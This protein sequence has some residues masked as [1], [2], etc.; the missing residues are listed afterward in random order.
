MALNYGYVKCTVVS[1]PRRKPSRHGR[2]TQ[3]HLHA[4]LK[5]PSGD[6]EASWDTAINVG[7]NDA[8]D[9]LRYKLVYDFHHPIIETLKAAGPGFHDLTGTSNFPALDFLRS[10]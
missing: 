8:D 10:N 1:E 4:T 7:T 3:Y 5:V 6:G 9:L 2:E